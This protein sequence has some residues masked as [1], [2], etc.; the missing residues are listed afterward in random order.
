MIGVAL[1]ACLLAAVAGAS[2]GPQ[3]SEID[4]VRLGWKVFNE[5]RCIACHAVWGEGA[6]LA[7]DLGRIETEFLSAGQ[8]A[9]VMWNHAPDMWARMVSKGIPVEPMSQEE[10]ESLFL[11]LYFVRFMDEP[12]DPVRGATLA[13]RKQCVACHATDPEEESVGPNFRTLGAYVNPIIWAQRMWN[14]APPMYREMRSQGLEWPTFEGDEMVDLIA[15]VRSIAGA[16]E[17]TYLEPGDRERGRRAFEELGCAACHGAG[18]FGAPPLEE[19]AR[20]PKTIGQMA[21]LMLNHAPAMA[22]KAQSAGVRWSEISAQQMVDLLTYFFSMRFFEEEGDPARGAQ[23]FQEKNCGLCHSESGGARE[24]R[25]EG[26]ATSPIEMARFMWE[27]GLGMLQRMEEMRVPW[28]T[29]EGQEFVDL[30]AY[31]N[32]GGS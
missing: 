21:G 11:F 2:E 10:M 8:L 20:R 31:L 26:E 6:N 12:G 32:A 22:E 25:R 4:R 28:P 14:H 1:V 19:L 9:G 13:Y 15:Y 7:P 3:R 29:F 23:V 27:H 17:R 24:L 5:K 16:P 30:L 18:E